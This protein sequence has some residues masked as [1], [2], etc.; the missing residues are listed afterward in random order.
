MIKTETI[1]NALKEGSGWSGG[2]Q[3]KYGKIDTIMTGLPIDLYNFYLKAIQETSRHRQW[4]LI[5]TTT[6]D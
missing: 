6:R 1:E 5:D 3:D 4:Y 2:A